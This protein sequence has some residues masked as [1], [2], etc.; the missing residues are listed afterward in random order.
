MERDYSCSFSFNCELIEKIFRIE[1]WFPKTENIKTGE[2]GT[3]KGL[4][5]DAKVCLSRRSS[6]LLFRC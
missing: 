4:S 6:V 2:E 5:V 1:H 3:M